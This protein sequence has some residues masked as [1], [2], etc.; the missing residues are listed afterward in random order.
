VQN[1][2]TYDTVVAVANPDFKLKP[3]MTA[4]V[5]ILVA[6][7]E[8]AVL[9]PNAAFRVRMDAAASGGASRQ[10]NSGRPAQPGVGSPLA[11]PMMPPARPAEGGVRQITPG[12]RQRVWVLQDGKPAE[13]P[14]QIG[15]S[16][17]QKTEILEGLSDGDKVIVGLGAASQGAT[18]GPNSPRLRL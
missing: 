11:P 5:K 7:R 9:V 17:G 2:V 1:V 18:T 12:S 10:Q 15:L 14:V 4:N 8:N 3:G 13:R 6:R 16:D